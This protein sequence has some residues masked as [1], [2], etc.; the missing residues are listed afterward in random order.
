MGAMSKI[1]QQFLPK[2]LRSCATVMAF[3]GTLGFHSGLTASEAAVDT[4]LTDLAQ[5]IP[6]DELAEPG[7]LIWPQ[8]VAKAAA[9]AEELELGKE[10]ALALKLAAAEAWLAA[11]EAEE[12]ALQT[13]EV[14][15]TE[16]LSERMRNRAGL[17]LVAAWQFL[18]ERGGDDEQAVMPGDPLS[19]LAAFGDFNALV[20]ARAGVVAGI[21]AFAEPGS[22]Q[23]DSISHFDRALSLLADE[24]AVHRTPVFTLRLHAM[25]LADVDMADIRRWLDE[26]QE[27]PGL[28]PILD[29]IFTAS[30]NLIGQVAPNLEAPRIDGGKAA[31]N[32]QEG[33]PL[34]VFFAASWSQQSDHMVPVVVD[35]QNTLKDA[36]QVIEVSLDTRDTAAQ[37]PAYIARHGIS[38]PI[39]GDQL[40][41]DG[42]LDDAWHID[43]IPSLILVDTKGRVASQNLA[44]DDPAD[45]KQR[46]LAAIKKLSEDHKETQP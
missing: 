34:L 32:V 10:G 9:Q 30:Q 31:V 37:I 39:I 40:G 24:A 8:T 3:C 21:I 1:F 20:T 25:E 7:S 5:T 18:A 41:W 35:L 6:P 38:H 23:T 11:G 19:E 26:H 36:I 42:E 4:L 27:D 12:S 22:E 13:K 46:V 17:S 45:T 28:Q 44:S 14:L 15:Q 2:K 33:V 29:A 43:G 16:R